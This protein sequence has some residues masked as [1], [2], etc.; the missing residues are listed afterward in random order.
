MADDY[1]MAYGSYKFGV[2]SSF[3]YLN[4]HWTPTIG[5]LYF[6]VH[7]ALPFN[8][9]VI[10]LIIGLMS[11]VLSTFLLIVICHKLLKFLNLKSHVQTISIFMLG[12]TGTL[13][14]VQYEVFRATLSDANLDL[15]LIAKNWFES[16]FLQSR[17]GQLLLW[18]YSTS[19]TSTRVLL[20]ALLILYVIKSSEHPSENGLQ[21]YFKY[22]IAPLIFALSWGLTTESLILIAYIAIKNLMFVKARKFSWK[23]SL[24]LI[25]AFFGVLLL[26]ISPGSQYRNSFIPERTLGDYLLYF[27]ANLWQMCW[28]LFSTLLIAW[29]SSRAIHVY[30]NSDANSFPKVL[31]RNFLLLAIS[32]FLTQLFIATFAYSAAYHWTA[33]IWI[34]YVFFVINFLHFQPK[35]GKEG[36]RLYVTNYVFYSYLVIL[37][38]ILSTTADSSAIRR[39][40]LDSRSAES[41]MI[42]KNVVRPVSARDNSGSIFGS[43]LEPDSISIVPFE[44]YL[45]NSSIFCYSRLPVGF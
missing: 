8:S 45:L 25:F 38:L 9:H 17:D 39:S 6:L 19:L 13:G 31:R 15:L 1:C 33:F 14:Y 5:Y 34:M 28:I 36:K 7:W 16:F 18:M 42:G 20:S 24:V 26:Y 23:N 37:V 10:A 32:A 44:G 2:L 41:L 22:E 43:D 40:K 27:G 30:I 35:I 12:F 21:S 4:T 3:L 29:L 11:L